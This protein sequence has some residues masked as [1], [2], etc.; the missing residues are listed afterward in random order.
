MS[1]QCPC[2]SQKEINNCCLPF[3]KGEKLPQSPEELM[4]SRYTAFCLKEIDYLAGT[5]D[6]ENSESFDREA[7]EEWAKQASFLNLDVKNSSEDGDEG[8]V[9]F[10][11][12][13]SV[14][15]ETLQHHE[16]SKFIRKDGKWFFHSGEVD[17]ENGY[18]YEESE[19]D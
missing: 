7:N 5:T 17:E 10:V 8:Q 13:F 3:I 4:R 14:D 18:F 9:E 6:P 2:Q 1:E 16:K 12:E 15:G 19:E 11:A